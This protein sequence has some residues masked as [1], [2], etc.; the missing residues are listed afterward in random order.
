MQLI[1]TLKTGTLPY[2][3]V[4]IVPQLF[5]DNVAAREQKIASTKR[6]W[7]RQAVFSSNYG[8][9]TLGKKKRTDPNRQYPL[10]GKT[11]NPND[12]KDRLHGIIEHENQILLKL[13]ERFKPERIANIHA[14][15][16]PAQAG[17]YADPRTDESGVALGFSSDKALALAMAERAAKGGAGVRGNK[18]TKKGK[19]GKYS[20]AIYPKDPRAVAVGKRQRRSH[21]TWNFKPRKGKGISLGTWASTAIK[22]KLNPSKNRSAIQIITVEVATTKRIE[23]MPK[24]KQADRRKEIESHAAAIREIFLGK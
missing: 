12:K 23:D 16:S 18:L 19:K 10:P 5:P 2:Y 4:T 9:Y 22:D 11:F 20:T 6:R 7:K 21:E 24:K 13:I 8:R 17:I 15:H 1:K 14:I 3:S